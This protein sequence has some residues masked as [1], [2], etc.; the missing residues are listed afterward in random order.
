MPIY[1]LSVYAALLVMGGLVG[2]VKSCSLM[3]LVFGSLSALGLVASISLIQSKNPWGYRLAM[4]LS[5]LLT[6]LFAYRFSLTF[7][8]M[9]SGM[10]LAVSLTVLSYLIIKGKQ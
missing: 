7:S 4:T 10:M 5:A 6:A 9:P 3:S 8:L 1:V 2:Y